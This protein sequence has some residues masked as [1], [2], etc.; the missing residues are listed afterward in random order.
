MTEYE[1]GQ[2][3][4]LNCVLALLQTYDMKLVDK[5]KVYEDVFEMRPEALK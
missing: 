3:H 2:W 5:R 4:A 1:R